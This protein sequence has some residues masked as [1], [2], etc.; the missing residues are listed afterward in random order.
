MDKAVSIILEAD[1][2]VVQRELLLSFTEPSDAA[3][4]AQSELLSR[5]VAGSS[6]GGDASGSGAV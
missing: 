5:P 3:W 2:A 1:D 6:D 4:R